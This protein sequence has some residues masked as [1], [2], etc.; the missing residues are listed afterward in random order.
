MFDKTY[1]LRQPDVRHTTTIHEHRAPT[2]DS[3]KLL[4]EYQEKAHQWAEDAV[5][6]KIKPINATVVEF[7]KCPWDMTYKLFININGRKISFAMDEPLNN[8]DLYEEIKDA[9]AR[10]LTSQIFRMTKQNYL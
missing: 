2:D 3:V 4:K 8:K 9:I 10:E 7:Q 5:V 1:L 6:H